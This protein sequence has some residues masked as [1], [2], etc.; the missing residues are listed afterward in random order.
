[1]S[2]SRREFLVRSG[3]LTL[4]AVTAQGIPLSPFLRCAQA[5]NIG[6]RYLVIVYLDGGN[7]GLNTIIP[8][9]D[10]VGLRTAYE[11]AR[12]IGFGGL[13]I[14]ESEVSIPQSVAMTDPLSGTSLGFHPGLADLSSMYDDGNVA[15]IQGVG[16]PEYDLSHSTSRVIWQSGDPT[17]G[18]LYQAGGWTGRHLNLAY[19]RDQIVSVTIG[20]QTAGDLRTLENPSL[21]VPR[22]E[23]FLF[24]FDSF[25]ANADLNGFYA[26][27]LEAMNGRASD[28][29]QPL[30]SHLGRVGDAAHQSTK[31]YP[32]LASLYSSWPQNRSA[33]YN[34]VGGLGRKLAEVAKC[35]Y[36]TSTGAPGIESR[37]FQCSKGGYDTHGD[38][39]GA[40]PDGHHFSLH[41]N[42]AQAA[43][44]FFEDMETMGLAEKVTMVVWSEFGRRVKQNENGT[45]HGSQG[46]M[47]VIGGSVNGGAY[48][49]HPDISSVDSNGNTI[50]SQD[51]LDPFRSTDLRDA[52]GT[53]MKHWINVPEPEILTDI[54]HLDDGALPASDYWTTQDF[55]LGFL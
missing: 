39:G 42:F 55:D 4:G 27:A 19:G 32:N 43:K 38:Q 24:P 20:D 45:D 22:L 29:D 26:G 28:T 37:F 5:E 10:P 30:L 46:P 52:L 6:D 53:I 11:D 15:I 12:G 35:I 9:D 40:S 47:F 7:D 23:E 18:P 1:M 14:G 34:A 25:A 44:V 50:Y 16:Y 3:L 48:G 8:I 36:G 13:R 31:N 2:I 49:N 33:D 17:R 51:P 41:Q 21:A 54:L